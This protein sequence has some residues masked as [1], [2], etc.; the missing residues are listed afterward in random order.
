MKTPAERTRPLVGAIKIWQE[1]GQG[2]IVVAVDGYPGAGKTTTADI[3]KKNGFQVIRQ[4]SYLLPLKERLRLLEKSSNREKTVQLSF[5]EDRRLSEDV[6]AWRNKADSKQVLVVE[7]V[8]LLDRRRYPK[9]W[10]RTVYLKADW[11]LTDA[12]R[13]EREKRRWGSQYVPETDPQSLF[14]IV[15]S[16]YRHWVAKERP[17]DTVDLV[18]EA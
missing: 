9:L 7:G 13:V 8:F 17:E 11:A 10:D 1:D 4:D 18:L 2:P 6:K 14:A 16:A 12:R 3:L 5:H 15:V